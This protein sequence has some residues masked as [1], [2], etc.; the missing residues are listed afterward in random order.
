VLRESKIQFV[1]IEL[2]SN[3]AR[4]VLLPEYGGRLHQLF[5]PFKGRE[6]PFLYGPGDVE[7]YRDRPTRG[8]SFP[9]APWPNRIAGSRF[10]WNG[11]EFHVPA[12]GKPNAIHG[13]VLDMAWSVGERTESSAELWCEL[14]EGWPWRGHAWQRFE[15]TEGRLEMRLEVHA[16]ES[17]FP[18]GCG[19]HPWFRRDAFGSDDVRVGVMAGRRYVLSEQLPTGETVPPASDFDLASAPRLGDRRLDDCY[20]GIDGPVTVDWGPVR[21]RMSIECA[22]PHVQVYTPAEAF[23][24][25][26]QT[27]APDAF[28]LA[29]R[30]LKGT[31]FAV[32]EPGLP[33]SL[34]SVWAWSEG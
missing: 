18:A 3:T 30:R 15:L 24:V 26:P 34:T 6:E 25:E 22:Q 17:P 16:A 2:R 11:A 29:A 8:G 23:C 7:A 10:A 32:A 27:C 20:A 33:L 19:W 28:N 21:L 9:M 13:Q 1:A 31:G 4:A 14:D 12:D 5:V